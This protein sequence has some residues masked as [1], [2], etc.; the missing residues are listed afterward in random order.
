MPQFG[1]NSWAH[2]VLVVVLLAAAVS[3]V[4]SGKIPNAVTYSA[5]AVG[6]I[7]HTLAWVLVDDVR[8]LGPAGSLGGF[9]AGFGPLLV[10]Y[11]AGGAG[12]GDA[13]L[14]GAVGALA[15]WS[16]ALAT[17]F[18]GLLVAALMAV[19]VMIRRRMVRRTAG[20][21][22]RFLV[23]SFTPGKPAPP[24]AAD[25][26]KIPLGL[27]LCLGAAAALTEVM[28]TGREATKLLSGP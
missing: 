27:A 18:Y 2:C 13:K 25:S 12:G 7:G 19:A 4:R 22:W 23:L 24:T 17:L 8:V 20:R 21:I 26:P 1:P 9:L 5:I 10:V 16:F 15:G 11:L 28:L 6:L 3:D 14:M